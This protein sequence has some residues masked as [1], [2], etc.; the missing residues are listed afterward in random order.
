MSM[1]SNSTSGHLTTKKSRMSNNRKPWED[2]GPQGSNSLMWTFFFQGS[3]KLQNNSTGHQGHNGNL[4]DDAASV[5]D[6]FF[7]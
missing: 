2:R 6:N 5:L 4:F 3:D 1:S 7:G